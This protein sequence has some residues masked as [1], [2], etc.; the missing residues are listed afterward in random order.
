LNL[1][2]IGQLS[3]LVLS[4]PKTDCTPRFTHQSSPTTIYIFFLELHDL[5]S[6]SIN[7]E[8]VVFVEALEI[9]G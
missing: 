4:L 8:P 5:T 1:T 7:E 2:T 9:L 6:I 3:G